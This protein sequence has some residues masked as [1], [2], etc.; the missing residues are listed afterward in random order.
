[1]R[2]ALT[3]CLAL[4]GTGCYRMTINN[5]NAEAAPAPVLED[6]WRST[7]VLDVVAIDTPMPLDSNC[8][9]TGW[10]RIEQ[11]LTVLDWFV[12]VFLAGW[13]YESTHVDL[14]CAKKGTSASPVTARPAATPG[15]TPTAPP[16]GAPT[17]TPTAPPASPLPPSSPP[18]KL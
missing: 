13:V 17:G 14:F 12:D 5:G 18:T 16:A 7:A 8:K 15:G 6:K 1:M 2:T 9:E 4:L 3:L 10:A 11:R